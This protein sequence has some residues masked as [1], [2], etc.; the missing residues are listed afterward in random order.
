MLK[1]KKILIPGVLVVG[2]VI[3]YMAYSMFLKPPGPPPPPIQVTMGEYT[4]N[5]ADPGDGN[6][7]FIKTIVVLTV[8]ATTP[9]VAA[10]PP[11]TGMTL[12]D[13]VAASVNDTILA[14]FDE[15]TPQEVN[16]EGHAIAKQ[17]LMAALKTKAK[18]KVSKIDFTE[19]LTH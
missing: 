4:A 16:A 18:L 13:P 2:L 7:H 10:V 12:A 11:I 14:T 1:N 19:L 17:R 6:D 8:P 9:T 3:G 5:L 15:M